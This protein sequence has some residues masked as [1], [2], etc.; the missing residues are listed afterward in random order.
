MSK[1]TLEIA[2]KQ[3][4]AAGRQADAPVLTTSAAGWSMPTGF[5]SSRT[6]CPQ[7]PNS[8]KPARIVEQTRL[9]RRCFGRPS[10]RPERGIGLRPHQRRTL[11]RV[12]RPRNGDDPGSEA[13][14][15][16][17]QSRRRWSIP[18]ARSDKIGIGLRSRRRARRF[19]MAFRRR[20]LSRRKATRPFSTGREITARTSRADS[21]FAWTTPATSEFRYE[22]TYKGPDL[23]V[24]EIGLDFELPL[25][26]DKLSWDRNAEYSYYPD[27]HIGR[28]RGRSGCPSGRAANR[29]RRRPALRLGRPC[30]GLQRLPQHET[31]YLHGQSDQQRRARASRYFPTARSTSGRPSGRMRSTSKCSTTTAAPP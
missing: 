30:L 22:F 26:F 18:P 11:P 31:A 9:S 20:R 8:G 29:S 16:E 15:A 1:G 12:D 28:P 17:E 13:A 7:F 5:R 10:A 6:R 21:R 4:A 24:R 25:T 3:L 2:V 14:S 19:G 27:D 23:W